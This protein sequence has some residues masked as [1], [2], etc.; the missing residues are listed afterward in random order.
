[1]HDLMKKVKDRDLY[2][3]KDIKMSLDLA[4]NVFF[5]LA[6]IAVIDGSLKK[7]EKE[8]LNKCGLCL[9]LDND[10]I[11]AVI[12]WSVNQMEINRKLSQDLQRSIQ[13]RD[14]IIEKQLFEN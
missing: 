4:I 5:Y 10:L 11:S 8:L 14:Q 3:V 7:S 6:A 9:G 2:E 12:R 13:G 1:V